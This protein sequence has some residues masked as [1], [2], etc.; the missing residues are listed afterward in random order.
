MGCISEA[1]PL[2]TPKIR[3]DKATDMQQSVS[4]TAE[5]IGSQAPT[6]RDNIVNFHYC[7]TRP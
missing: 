4:Y 5:N 3:T 7:I 6:C 1:L 2:E